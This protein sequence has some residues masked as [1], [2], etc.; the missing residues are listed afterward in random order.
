MCAYCVVPY[1][2]GAERSRDPESVMKEVNDLFETGYREVT[3]LGQN[4]DSYNMGERWSSEHGI[5]RTA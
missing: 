1:V 4:V 2:R 5:S 3:L